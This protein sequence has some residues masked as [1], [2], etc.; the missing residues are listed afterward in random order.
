M[1]F[2]NNLIHGLEPPVAVRVGAICIVAPQPRA[3]CVDQAS[4]AIGCEI[5]NI[6]EVRIV[7][8]HGSDCDLRKVL[9]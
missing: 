7:P 8:A 2:T 3:I 1:A 4:D 5:E 9:E 6:G